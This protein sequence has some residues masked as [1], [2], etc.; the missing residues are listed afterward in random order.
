MGVGSVSGKPMRLR[1]KGEE[2]VWRYTARTFM[3]ALK[4]MEK[5]SH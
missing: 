5:Q 4:I 2:G 1:Q 3:H